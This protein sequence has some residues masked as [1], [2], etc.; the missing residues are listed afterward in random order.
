[1]SFTAVAPPSPR[2]N[3]VGLRFIP[4]NL[5]PV[6]GR[7]N[8]AIDDGGPRLRRPQHRLSRAAIG[9]PDVEPE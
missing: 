7:K 9:S 6:I 1:M 8:P 3:D 4:E 2:T 5:P